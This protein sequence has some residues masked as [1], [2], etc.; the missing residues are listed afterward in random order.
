MEVSRYR[1]Y[2]NTTKI[3]AQDNTRVLSTILVNIPNINM[4]VDLKTNGES[5]SKAWQDIFDDKC[6]TDW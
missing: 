3:V 2:D 5:L 1:N 6:E 4:A